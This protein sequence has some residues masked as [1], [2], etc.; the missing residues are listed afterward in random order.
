MKLLFTARA[1]L[2]S[3]PLLTLLVYYLYV[4]RVE[5]AAFL[6]KVVAYWVQAGE[7]IFTS[8]TSFRQWQNCVSAH[9]IWKYILFMYHAGN[10]EE[11]ELAEQAIR[12]S[13]MYITTLL[14]HKSSHVLIYSSPEFQR[15]GLQVPRRACHATSHEESAVE[16]KQQSSQL[17]RS[18]HPNLWPW[19]TAP[20]RILACWLYNAAWRSLRFLRLR[21]ASWT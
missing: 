4:I 14:N 19:K 15:R 10:R 2:I 17:R 1:I 8:K 13:Y 3:F 21:T 18:S 20:P 5:M 9:E 7:N 6:S 11:T 16:G 12:L